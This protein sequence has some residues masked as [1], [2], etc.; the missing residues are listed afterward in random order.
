MKKYH[1]MQDFDCGEA[2][3]GFVDTATQWKTALQ[4]SHHSHAKNL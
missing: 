2:R 4:D 3:Q 1:P